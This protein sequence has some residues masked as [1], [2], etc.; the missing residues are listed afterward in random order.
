MSGPAA[1]LVAA[2]A[3]GLVGALLVPPA[4][5]S[6]RP[7][8][9]A[10]RPG[11]AS[12]G[13]SRGV[14]VLLGA[15]VAGAVLAGLPLRTVVLAGVLASAGWA[16]SCLLARRRR[17]RAAAED[18]ERVRETC[19]ALAADL[20]AGRPA[21][22]A[23]D[24]ACATWPPLAPVAAAHA[25]GADVPDGL[26]SLAHAP[27][28]GD[29]RLVAAAWDVAHRTGHGLSAALSRVADGLR[30]QQ[31]TRRVVTS[32]L[33]SARSTARLLAGLPVLALLMG[34]GTGGDP[35]TFL[36]ATPVGLACLAGGLA[37]GL[38]GLW[39]IEVI[40]DEVEVST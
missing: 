19:E 5:G 20:R 9:S 22:A 27:G 12:Y 3:A 38:A 24:R 40:A 30:A 1:I 36:L 8:G 39:W 13:G 29:L 6:A 18:A 25:V 21:G 28:C 15:G 23:L 14:P 31:A 33:A 2:V 35:W 10:G 7:A 17:R 37:L 4:T 26:R 34:T 16:G 11:R 32:E